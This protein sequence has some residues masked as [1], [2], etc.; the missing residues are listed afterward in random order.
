MSETEFAI[1]RYCGV[2]F[3]G[4][5]VA[6]MVNLRRGERDVVVRLARGFRRRGFS[7]VCL[8]AC[9]ERQVL[10][11][12]HEEQLRSLLFSPD[13]RAFLEGFGYRYDTVGEALA[14]LRARMNALGAAF[15]H[16]IG[17]F[18]GYPLGDVRGFLRDPDGCVLCG[19]W[20]VY[21]NADEA[22]RTF[23]RFRRCS[24]CICRHMDRGRTLSQI[25][26]IG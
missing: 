14:Q 15:P 21:E 19:A 13:V 6:S 25:F 12:Y 10:Y 24:D 2:T 7:F 3:A 22:V 11:V 4:L 18:L 1:G 20:K 5:K 9:G 23:E 26:N 17:V 16:E 8:R